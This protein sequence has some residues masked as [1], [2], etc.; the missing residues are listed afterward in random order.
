MTNEILASNPMDKLSKVILEGDLSKLSEQEKVIY[1]TK[2]CESLGLNPLTKPFQYIKLK[3]DKESLYATKDCT[4]QLRKIRGISIYKIEKEKVD[5]IFIVTAYARDKDGREDVSTGV[6]YLFKDIGEWVDSKNGKKYFKKTG[7]VPLSGDDLAN[8]LMKAET[9]AK[10]RVTLSIAGL[11]WLDESEVDSLSSQNSQ[12]LSPNLVNI[13]T[14]VSELSKRAEEME[15]KEKLDE[16]QQKEAAPTKNEKNKPVL[17]S[18][19]FYDDDLDTDVLLSIDKIYQWLEMK[20]DSIKDEASL[21][22][23][24]KFVDKNRSGGLKVYYNYNEQYQRSLLTIYEKL[25]NKRN[26]IMAPYIQEIREEMKDNDND[27]NAETLQHMAREGD[28]EYKRG[29]KV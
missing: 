26:M 12:S 25:V 3:E 24:D 8:A 13:N 21:N 18:I 23:F 22:K 28:E 10:R 6:V 19:E 11:G 29:I 1:Y 17:S 4:E 9:K 27:V 5:Q 7:A 20:V 16:R 2:T 15:G 14:T